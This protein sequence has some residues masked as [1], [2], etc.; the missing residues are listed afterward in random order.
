[1]KLNKDARIEIRLPRRVKEQFQAL[2]LKKQTT[3]SNLLLEYILNTIKG[4][5]NN[6]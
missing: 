3:I 1:M 2:A 5:K 4:E 6:G